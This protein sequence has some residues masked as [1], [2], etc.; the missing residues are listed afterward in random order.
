MLVISAL[1]LEYVRVQVQATEAGVPVNPTSDTVYLAFMAEGSTPGS[2][3]WKTASWETDASTSPT[4]D[5]AR[6]LVGPGGVITLSAGSVYDVWTKW[7]DN[8][9]APVKKAGPIR[10]I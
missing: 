9:E 6:A 10:V 4:T 1:S 2:S 3:D 8:P 5:Y 7:T